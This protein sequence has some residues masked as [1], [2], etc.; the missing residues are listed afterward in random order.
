MNSCMGNG[1]DKVEGAGRD[2]ERVL[3]EKM[4]ELEEFLNGEFHKRVMDFWYVALKYYIEN[5]LDIFGLEK[6]FGWLRNAP[7]EGPFFY[8]ELRYKYHLYGI[9]DEFAKRVREKPGTYPESISYSRVF[10]MRFY[11]GICI[12]FYNA[13]VLHV[14][15]S[16]RKKVSFIVLDFREAKVRRCSVP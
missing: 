3:E 7:V 2:G 11:N 10:T 5:V 9:I 1:E 8:T 6:Q 15:D 13:V 14:G 12:D 4:R 16:L